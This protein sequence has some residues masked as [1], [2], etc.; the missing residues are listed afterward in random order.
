MV[1]VDF[2][3]SANLRVV[4]LGL[5]AVFG[6]MTIMTTEAD[7]R[8]N[9]SGKGVH[10]RGKVVHSRAKGIKARAAASR[11]SPPYSAIVVDAN[12]GAVLHENSADSPRHPASLTKVMT[13]YLLFERLD[14][15]KIKL[16]N[17][18]DV[19]A[20]A[21]AQAPSKLGLKVGSTIRV[22]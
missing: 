2:R 9:K 6:A 12:S 8:R 3:K 11:Y 4:V 22:E 10:A 13:L 5:I 21:A 19:S 16:D 18:M 14:A 20:H 15:G 1:S 17:E 7:A